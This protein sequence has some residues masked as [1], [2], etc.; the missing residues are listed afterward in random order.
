[1]GFAIGIIVTGIVA[2]VMGMNIG[3]RNCGDGFGEII[4]G[5]ASEVLVEKVGRFDLA[6]WVFI[7]TMAFIGVKSIG[8]FIR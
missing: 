6:F 7:I 5:N 3:S 2:G 1:M 8:K 4:V